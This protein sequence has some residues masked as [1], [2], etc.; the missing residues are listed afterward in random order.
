[1]V[2]FLRVYNITYGLLLF[3]SVFIILSNVKVL[4]SLL[5][6]NPKLSGGAFAHIGVGMMLIGILFSLAIPKWFRLTIPAC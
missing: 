3:A 5:K 4:S 6:L 2:S 1:M